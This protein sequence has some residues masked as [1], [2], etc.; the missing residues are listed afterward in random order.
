MLG[1][2]TVHWIYLLFSILIF[3]TL[4]RKREIV[5]VGIAGILAVVLVYTG[6]PVTA[7]Q[8][9]CSSIVAGFSEVLYIFI[10]IALIL[11]M[12]L[13]M[14]ECGVDQA[15]SRPLDRIR[16]GPGRTFLISALSCSL[17]HS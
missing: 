13:A 12:T 2:T 9:L 15:L 8:A 5:L 16:T 10:G 11:T 14:K 1:L 6:S 3:V 7:F 4:V 17:F